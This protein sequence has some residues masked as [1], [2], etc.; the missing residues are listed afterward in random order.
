MSE[1]RLKKVFHNILKFIELE[2]VE[3]LYER[4]VQKLLKNK[5]SFRRKYISIEMLGLYSNLQ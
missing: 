5:F 1:R 2:L 4:L 3:T